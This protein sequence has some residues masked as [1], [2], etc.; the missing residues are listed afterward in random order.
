[1]S[2]KIDKRTSVYKRREEALLPGP[3]VI[4]AMIDR[5]IKAGVSVSYALLDS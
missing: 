2:E 3:Q 4:T 5:A 1:M